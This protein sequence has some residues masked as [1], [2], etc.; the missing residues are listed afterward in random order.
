M[1]DCPM[2]LLMFNSN[3]GPNSAPLQD[4]RLHNFGDLDVDLSMSLKVICDGV[5]LL[6]IYSFLS[7]VNMA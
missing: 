5:F 7:I 4:I 1:Y 6:P 2:L 3:I